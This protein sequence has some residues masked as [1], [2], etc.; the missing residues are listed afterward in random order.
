MRRRSPERYVFFAPCP[1]GAEAV[2]HAEA[3]ALGLAKA[4][5][6]VGGV[7]FEGPETEGW[8]AVLHLRTAVRVYRHLARF[9]AAS[10]DDLYRG[11]LGV[12]WDRLLGPERTFSVSAKVSES[13]HRHSGFVALRVKDAVADWFRDRFGVRPRVD[14]ESPDLRLMVYVF[15]DRCTLSLDVGGRSLHRRGYRVAATP[16]PVGECLAAAAVGLSEWDRKSPFLDPFCGSG[17]LLIE[18]AL[19]ASNTAPGLLEA[20]PYAFERQPGFDA[21][22]WEEMR[23][24][25]RRAVQLPAKLILRGADLDPAAAL[26]ARKNARAAGFGDLIRVETADVRDFAPRPGWGATVI[27]NP[28]YGIRLEEEESLL[29]LYRDLGLVLRERCHGYRVHLFVAG[30]RLAKALGL[31]PCRSWAL[32]NGGLRCRLNRYEIF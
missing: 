3:A 17:T 22:R 28:P 11:A 5:A 21:Q 6:Q 32:F 15:R 1:P 18:A 26:A 24:A 23:E 13:S 4:E 2:L 10:A 7:R 20:G 16:A 30:R 25:A 12:A 14:A 29:P 27:S 31:K 9:P 8:R 19:L